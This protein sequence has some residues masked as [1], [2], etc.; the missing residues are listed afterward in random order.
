MKHVVFAIFAHPDDE[1]LVAGTLLQLANEG[2]E[3]NLVAV[4]SGDAGVNPTNTPDLA[5]LRLAEWQR[6]AAIINAR[7]TYPLHYLDGKLTDEDLPKLK[8]IIT[9]LIEVHVHDAVLTLITFDK[10][11]ITGHS[12]HKLVHTLVE[13]LAGELHA[14][15]M[16]FRLT[17]EHAQQGPGTTA[18]PLAGYNKSEMDQINDVSEFL[19]SKRAIMDCHESQQTDMAKWQRC[20]AAHLGAECFR[21]E[22]Y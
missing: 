2:A 19:G 13:Q 9:E 22:A 3:I 16:Y 18:Y 11:G 4:T 5:A 17:K 21:V 14:K 1:T 10:D 6:S 15:T 20:D 12:D 7:A 8:A